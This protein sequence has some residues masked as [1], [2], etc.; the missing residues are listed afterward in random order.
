MTMNRNRHD[1]ANYV[2]QRLQ[3]SKERL[4]AEFLTPE[5]M[6]T[7]V[8]DDVFPADIARAIYPALPS[9]E[10][11]I[12]K[13]NL[14][15]FKYIGVQ[16]NHY[17]S[18][19]EEILYAFQ[20]V[21]VVTLLK[22]ITGI[23]Y[24]I[25]DENLY[26]GG[27][28]MMV[29]GQYITPHLDNSH[30]RDRTLYRMLNLLYYVT[31]DWKEGYGGNLELWDKDLRQKKRVLNSQFNRLVMMA[32][33][34]SSWHSVNPIKVDGRR[35]CISNYYFSPVTLDAQD[36]FHVTSFRGR[37]GQAIADIALRTDTLLRNKIRK[38]FPRG[39]V[40]NPHMYKRNPAK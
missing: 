31:P 2:I 38:V 29:K 22:E 11:L 40:K 14:R 30:N 24:L 15:E 1:L 37:P 26:A 21:R 23:P 10:E 3:D 39:I 25:P 6:R 13:K 5:Q 16:M 8:L 20:D 19:L 9:Q 33:N 4:H 32:T 34:R 12:L 35:C 18:L 7:C 28:S 17:N 36:Y 27:I